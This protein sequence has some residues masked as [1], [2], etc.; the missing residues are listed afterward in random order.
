TTITPPSVDLARLRE[1]LTTLRTLAEATD[2][3]AI[4]DSNNLARGMKRFVDDLSSY[5]LLGYY[6]NGKLDGKFHAITV[7]VK[8]PGVSVRARR[9]YLALTPAAA[10]TAV[11]T[12]V[13]AAVA[14]EARAVETALGALGAFTR[15]V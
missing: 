9:G 14:S 3:L 6:S 13:S 4:V 10:A 8:R 5:Y 15:D 1:R 7:R 11:A 2:G 12:P